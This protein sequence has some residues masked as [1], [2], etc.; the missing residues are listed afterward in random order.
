MDEL[1]EL[2]EP[3]VTMVTVMVELADHYDLDELMA[4]KVVMDLNQLYLN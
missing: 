2:D 3:E 1:D 4:A